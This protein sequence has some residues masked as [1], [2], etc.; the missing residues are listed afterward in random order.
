MNK[1]VLWGSTIVVILV[2]TAS[3]LL[4]SQFRSA[5]DTSGENRP[6]IPHST[7]QSALKEKTYTSQAVIG[8]IGDVL[9]H[10]T[11]YEDAEEGGTYDFMPMFQDVETFLQSPDFMIANQESLPGGAHLGVSSYPAFNSPYEIVDALQKLGVDAVTTANNHTLDKGAKGALS[12]ISHYEEIG[13]PYTGSFKNEED[14]KDI[15]TFNVNGISF[16]LLAYTYGTNGIPVPQG[17]DYLVNLIDLEL[18]KSDIKKAKELGVDMVI[19]A[20]HW[21]N[22]YERYPNDTQ[23]M[24]AR[25]LTNAGVDLLIGHHPHV[26]QPIEKMTTEDGREAVV[27]YSLGN[28]LSGQEGELKNIGGIANITVQK[29]I[30]ENGKRISFPEIGFQPTFVTQSRYENY[31]ILPLN[32]AHQSG[33]VSFPEEEMVSHVMSNE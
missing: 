20:A 23:E 5:E 27:I 18:M 14:R 32:A 10:N 24:L 19:L 15:R 28:F 29:V 33:L 7:I 25:E 17:Q 22:E 30:D 26:L 16:A 9:L 21:G 6:P 13:M 12:A 2:F 8:A 31:R 3:A 4:L 11:V 1:K